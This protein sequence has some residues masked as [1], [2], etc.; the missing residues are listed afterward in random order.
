MLMRIS[1]LGKVAMSRSREVRGAV[2]VAW[3]TVRIT[4][5]LG[6]LDGLPLEDDM[7]LLTGLP[8][9]AAA[10]GAVGLNLAEPLD[11]RRVGTMAGWAFFWENTWR[12]RRVKRGW[13]ERVRISERV[14]SKEDSK[15]PDSFEA[16]MAGCGAV[17]KCRIQNSSSLSEDGS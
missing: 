17:Y 8:L 12:L 15:K 16:M 11:G 1:S 14:R 10:D 7:P 5:P 6:L 2:G 9:T 4:V 13:M 3:G